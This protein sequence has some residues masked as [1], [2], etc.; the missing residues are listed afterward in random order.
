MIISAIQLLDLTAILQLGA[1]VSILFFYQEM[2]TYVVPAKEREE[3]I[4]QLLAWKGQFHGDLSDK[5]ING[6]NRLIVDKDLSNFKSTVIHLGKLSF[7]LLLT[8]MLIAAH[9][10]TDFHYS[11]DCILASSLIF[12]CYSIVAI[13]LLHLKFYNHKASFLIPAITIVTISASATVLG[14]RMENQICSFSDH[15][16][17]IVIGC[18]IL[19]IVFTICRFYYDEYVARS[20]QESC[21]RLKYGFEAFASWK[22]NP[23]E[24]NFLKIPIEIRRL[25]KRGREIT[26]ENA[27]SE[28]ESFMLDKIQFLLKTQP[29]FRHQADHY[30]H[31]QKLYIKSFLP[32]TIR[33]FLGLFTISLLCIYILAIYNKYY[34]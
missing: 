7:V 3:V 23:T 6:L 21:N 22:V 27:Q 34:S 10:R 30:L 12:L 4:K 15:A 1:G 14:L 24:N 32:L 17:Y 19:V 31:L 11:Y 13:L 16:P 20:L 2:L 18:F 28:F 9:E 8:F 29:K 5:D 26:P 25:F 33:L